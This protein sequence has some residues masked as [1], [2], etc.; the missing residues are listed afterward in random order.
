V[1]EIIRTVSRGIALKSGD[2]AK[3]RVGGSPVDRPF[4]RDRDFLKSQRILVGAP[5]ADNA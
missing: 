5:S 1:V 2:A 3:G 4:P